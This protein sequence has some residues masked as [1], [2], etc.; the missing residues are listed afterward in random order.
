MNISKKPVPGD[1]IA[2]R[3][4]QMRGRKRKRME[5]GIR[6]QLMIILT[7][8]VLL[9]GTIIAGTSYYNAKNLASDQI[10]NQ[11]KTQ[12][13]NWKL[14]VESYIEEIEHTKELEDTLI[15]EDLST[16]STT[17]LSW[18]RASDEQRGGPGTTNGSEREVIYERI[19]DIELG[20]SGYV[21]VLGGEGDDKGHYIV[22]D[23]RER[24]G[25]YLLDTMD[26]EG[27]LFVQDIVANGKLTPEEP[28][29]IEYYW[30][31]NDE[32]VPSLKVAAVTYYEPWDALI[33]A[34]AYFRDF[35]SNVEHN[36]KE[37]LLDRMA[38]E[39]I[40]KTGYLWVIK[41]TGDDKGH[42]ILSEDRE[43][44][45]EDL[46]N[47]TQEDDDYLFREIIEEGKETP[48]KAFFYSYEWTSVEKDENRKKI[49]AVT[50]VEEWDWVIG[51]S[52]YEDEFMEEVV[53]LRNR[54]MMFTAGE[55]IVALVMSFF[56]GNY[57]SRTITNPLK[58]LAEKAERMRSADT[59]DEDNE[60]FKS[61]TKEIRFL[62]DSLDSAREAQ[63]QRDEALEKLVESEAKF[64]SLAEMLPEAVFEADLNSRITYFNQNGLRKFGYTKDELIGKRSLVEVVVPEQRRI[65]ASRLRE[66]RNGREPNPKEYM[67]IRKDG[68]RF[69]IIAHTTLNWSEGTPSGFRGVIIDIT[70]IKKAEEKI[71]EERKKA[72]FYL[73]MLG[74]DIGNLHMG[75]S[76]SLE[77]AQMMRDDKERLMDTLKIAREVTNRSMKL[78]ESVMLLSRIRSE[79]P[80]LERIDV[81]PVIEEAIGQIRETY[82]DKDLRIHLHGTS[83]RIDA[84]PILK[85]AI[86]NIIHNAVKI[87]AEVEPWV[88]ITIRDSD[89]ADWMAIE[90]CDKGP[91]IPDDMKRKIFKRFWTSGKGSRIG[92]GLSIVMALV[93]RYNGKMYVLDRVPKDHTKGTKFILEFPKG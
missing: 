14:I 9:L 72:E 25:E 87:Q 18:M 77:L 68:R 89:R 41:G 66:L 83:K 81:K 11:L 40:G 71:K 57:Y 17:I 45:G 55:I 24:D 34:S 29:L 84:E 35:R 92:L 86:Y 78:T 27:N 26:S 73:D 48:S 2:R 20:R 85:Q 82:P 54:I 62:S 16:M 74:H 22:S 37:R 59:V 56:I 4:L 42:Y 88:D 61:S 39:T 79:R 69:P 46:W 7:T 21:W 6:G 36:M 80:M 38:N 53:V 63:V 8:V 32:D 91:G 30:Q 5:I 76:S 65:G 13:E 93:E 49:S 70:D 15:R 3:V 75:L 31:N 28:Y 47:A 23:N 12:S 52:A 44:D 50:Y 51:A 19:A 64:R 90:I 67:A 60:V 33:G 43:R 58:M 10:R 1:C